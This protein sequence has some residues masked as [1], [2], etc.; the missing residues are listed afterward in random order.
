[1]GSGNLF[2]TLLALFIAYKSS[3]SG[4]T[5]QPCRKEHTACQY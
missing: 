5:G 2:M 4:S 1:M 3:F